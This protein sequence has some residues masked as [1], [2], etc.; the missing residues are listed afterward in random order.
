VDWVRERI[1]AVLSA[2]TTSTGNIAKI[3]SVKNPGD[4]PPSSR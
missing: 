4:R 3:D 2:M 1:S